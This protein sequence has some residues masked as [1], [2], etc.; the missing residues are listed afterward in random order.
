MSDI[1]TATLRKRAQR[2]TNRIYDAAAA[3]GEPLWKHEL[4]DVAEVIQALID[5]LPKDDAS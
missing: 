2:A 3:D 5:A 4:L 1:D